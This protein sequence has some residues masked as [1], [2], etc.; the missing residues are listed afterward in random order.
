M[1]IQISINYFVGKDTVCIITILEVVIILKWTLL[2][3]V[4]KYPLKLNQRHLK[5]I[6]FLGIEH[7]LLR[8]N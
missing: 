2:L 7:N 6:Q 4:Y 5:E 8:E 3:N 1:P